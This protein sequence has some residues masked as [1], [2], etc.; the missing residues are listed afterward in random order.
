MRHPDDYE[1]Q[2]EEEEKELSNE[3]PDKREPPKEPTK[4][5]ANEFNELINKEK[6]DINSELFKKRFSFQRP[7]E[8]GYSTNLEGKV[9]S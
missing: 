6:T 5:D 2:S 1:S 3:K 8:A 4:I 9:K 7:S